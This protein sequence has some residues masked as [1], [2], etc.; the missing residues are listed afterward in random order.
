MEAS[1]MR[2]PGGSLDFAGRL[3]WSAAVTFVLGFGLVAYLGIDGGGYDPLVHDQIG[4]AIWWVLLVG[5][6]VGALPQLG[7]S[8]LSLVGLGLFAAFVAWCALSLTWT[9]STERAAAELAR[10]L[11][12]LGIL[13]LGLSLKASRESQRLVMAVAAAIVL[14]AVLALLSRLHPAWF[15]SAEQTARLLQD[16]RERLSYPLNYWNALGALVAIGLPLV[17][18]IS[19]AAK[20]VLVRAVAAASMPAMALA[21]FFTLSRGGIAAAVLALAVFLA[22]TDDRAPKLLTLAIAAA[23]GGI[24][25]GLAAGRDALR[26]GLAN[27]TAHSQG[28]ELLLIGVVVC[29]AV[30]LIHALISRQLIAGRRPAWTV[31]SRGASRF[32]IGAAV[33]VIAIAGLAAHAPH[34]FSNAIDEF[35]GGGNAGT[36]TARLNSFAGESRYALWKSAIAENATAPLIGT[37]S[38]TFE[39]WW[40]RDAAGTESVHDAHSF[41]LQ[42]LGEL[43]IVGL[44]LLLGFVVVVLGFGTREVI[45]SAAAERSQLAAA[46]AGCLAFFLSAA[47]DWTWQIPAL[48]AA[49]LLLAAPLLMAGK[50]IESTR[51]VLRRMPVRVLVALGSLVVIVAIAIP[52]ASTSLVRSSEAAAR[53]GDLAA[54]L[55]DARSA[56]NVQPGAASPRLQEALVLE[57]RGELAAAAAAALAATEREETNWRNWLVLSRIEAE[58]GRAVPSLRAYREARSLNPLSELFQK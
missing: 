54:A 12:Y 47:I 38:G 17:L 34:R 55:D 46:L 49:T 22:V 50:S 26:H 16:S 23:G 14:I 52:L 25:I 48:P 24:L 19:A 39:L 18:Q 3:D 27:S 2:R 9:E 37:G 20:T 41:Y 40:N 56:Q 51:S 30:G 58:R 32:A 45:R 21:I 43:G 33:V 28:D 1:S 8:R 57:L 11:S 6:L 5:V 31:P 13:S 29:G 35:R 4:I 10:M 53:S 42:T 44:L 36:G 15:P 7:F